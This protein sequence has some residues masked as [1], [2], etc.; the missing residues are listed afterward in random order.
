VELVGVRQDV[1]F[2]MEKFEVSERRAC[3]LNHIDRSSYRYQPGPD[4]NAD[5]RRKLTALVARNRAG[6][7]GGWECCWNRR[8]K[9]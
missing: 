9:R 3:E 7:I 4:G 2:A 8:A 5:L 1:A 6:A